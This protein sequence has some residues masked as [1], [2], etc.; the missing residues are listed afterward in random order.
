MFAHLLIYFTLLELSVAL[1]PVFLLFLF[2]QIGALIF[3]RGLKTESILTLGL[4]LLF[5]AL[6]IKIL[7]LNQAFIQFLILVSLFVFGLILTHE[8]VLPEK[9]KLKLKGRNYGSSALLLSFWIMIFYFF[10]VGWS[11]P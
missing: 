8:R 2:F 10:L 7:N 4:N 6:S 1:S 9:F 11:A 3:Y 5:F